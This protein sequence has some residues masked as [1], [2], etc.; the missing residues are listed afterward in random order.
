MSPKISNRV[1]EITVHCSNLYEGYGLFVRRQ[2][3]GR[4]YYHFS[5]DSEV[6]DILDRISHNRAWR[7][8]TVLSIYPVITYTRVIKEPWTKDTY[9]SIQAHANTAAMVQTR[10]TRMLL[11]IDKAIADE[12]SFSSEP[13]P[14]WLCTLKEFMSVTYEMA[15]TLTA[16]VHDVIKNM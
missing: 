9:D 7:V 11:K 8:T 4:H 6:W 5:C 1:V 13:N 15:K 2:V 10:T 12:L 16:H 3:S 14:E